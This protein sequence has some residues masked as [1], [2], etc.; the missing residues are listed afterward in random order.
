MTPTR[1]LITVISG[2]SGTGKGTL[3]AGLM[4]IDPR[5]HYAVSATTRE[6]RLGEAEGVSYHFKSRAEFEALIRDGEVLEWDEFC[7][8]LY[9]TLRSEL[10]SRID[11]GND[12]ILDLTVKGAEAIKRAFPDDAISVFILP[13]SIPELERRIRGRR[14]ESEEQ[15]RERVAQAEREIPFVKD[16]DYVI[17][18]DSLTEGPKR[19]KTIIDAERQKV[20]RNANILEAMG[21]AALTTGTD[22]E[23]NTGTDPETAPAAQQTD[24]GTDPENAAG[25]SGK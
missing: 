24:T 5:M 16:F 18:S 15:L 1:G 11:A 9:G 14:R 13:P 12:V 21:F 23:S 25:H 19:L 6:M 3:I 10:Q 20:R 2:P 8:N 7:G 22:P 4:A 17:I